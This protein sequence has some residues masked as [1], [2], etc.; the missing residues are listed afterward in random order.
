[1]RLF[2][3]CHCAIDR[4]PSGFIIGTSETNRLIEIFYRT[5][6]VPSSA[7]HHRRRRR[8]ADERKWKHWP[9]P[10]VFWCHGGFDG[11]RFL[12]SG[13]LASVHGHRGCRANRAERVDSDATGGVR[14]TP[15]FPSST[16]PRNPRR[17]LSARSFRKSA[18]IVPFSPTCRCVM[19]P[20][21]FSHLRM[22]A[23]PW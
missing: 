15:D 5:L 14:P 21:G 13:K 3:R 4:S 17:V 19:S 12:W 1:M 7:H 10:H 8:Q 9:H 2:S 18:F 20:S 23:L 22:Q 16:R 6:D 11:D